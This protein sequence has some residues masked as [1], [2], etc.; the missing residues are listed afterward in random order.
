MLLKKRPK[1]SECLAPASEVAGSE[2]IPYHFKKGIEWFAN[3]KMV[4]YVLLRPLRPAIIQLEQ[5]FKEA[6]SNPAQL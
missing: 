6:S 1:K 3:F 4:W 5:F 2:D